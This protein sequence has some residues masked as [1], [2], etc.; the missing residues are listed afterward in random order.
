MIFHVTLFKSRGQQAFEIPPEM[1]F[2]ESVKRVRFEKSG[3]NLIMTPILPKARKAKR[4]S[5]S[6]RASQ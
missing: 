6:D 4:T 1:E 2:P 5:T 3:D